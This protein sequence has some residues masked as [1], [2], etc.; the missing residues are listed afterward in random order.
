M[1]TCMY[2]HRVNLFSSFF[3]ADAA[4]AGEAFPFSRSVP[5]LQVSY[6]F[7]IIYIYIP[8]Y[9]IYIDIYIYIYSHINIYVY[10][11]IYI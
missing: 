8:I 6:L 3:N 1:Y 5:L 4:V 10:I 11:Y 7:M 9:N 2:I